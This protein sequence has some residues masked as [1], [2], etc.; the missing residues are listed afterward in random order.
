MRPILYTIAVLIIFTALSCLKIGKNE[1]YLRMTGNVEIISHHIPDTVNMNDVVQISAVGQAYDACWSDINFLLTKT[2][3]YEY[4]LQAFGTYESY[5]VCPEA[6]V[7][8]DTVI[9]ITAAHTGLYKFHVYKGPN[10]IETDTL[11]VK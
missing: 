9:T 1:Y 10:D 4:T 3:D 6:L 5:G 7:S 8:G 2:N 11:I